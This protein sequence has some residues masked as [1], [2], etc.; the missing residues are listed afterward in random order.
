[1]Q[2][3]NVIFANFNSYHLGGKLSKPQVNVQ[4]KPQFETDTFNGKPL[5]VSKP[6]LSELALEFLGKSRKTRAKRTKRNKYENNRT[7]SDTRRTGT[8]TQQNKNWQE[9]YIQDMLASLTP[10][11]HGISVEYRNLFSKQLAATPNANLREELKKDRTI[12]NLD[13]AEQRISSLSRYLKEDMVGF[14]SPSGDHWFEKALP[15]FINGARARKVPAGQMKD[16]AKEIW[17]LIAKADPYWTSGEFK[18]YLESMESSPARDATITAI[19]EIAIER[20]GIRRQVTFGYKSLMK[21]MKKLMDDGC[22]YTGVPMKRHSRDPYVCISA[23]HIFPHSKGGADND[24]NFFMASSQSNSDRG[25]MPLVQFLKGKN[26]N[27][28]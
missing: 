18:K 26:A 3:N 28:K 8:K 9:D 12:Y 13:R 7:Q 22:A 5:S 14:I 16:A 25:N 11:P 6:S 27:D 21:D 15:N 2:T 17:G 10:G 19:E 4:T 20:K 1:M 24:F 23:E